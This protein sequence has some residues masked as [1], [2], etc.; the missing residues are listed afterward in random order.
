MKPIGIIQSQGGHFLFEQT[1]ARLQIPCLLIQNADDF[2]QIGGLILHGGESTAQYLLLK[3]Q[4]YIEKIK[5]FAA[6]NKPILGVCAGCIL[7]SHYQS[8]KVSGLGLINIS[9]ERNFYGSQYDSQ[10]TNSDEGNDILFIRAPHIKSVQSPAIALQHY[11]GQAILVKQHNCI[12]A[13][14][15]PEALQTEFGD[16]LFNNLFCS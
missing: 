9:I 16:D 7:L 4:D 13:T 14:F 3:Q 11:Q 15:H 5:Q 2:N 12:G 10:L 8:E 6:E 1:F